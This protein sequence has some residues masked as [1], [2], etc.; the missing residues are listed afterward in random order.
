MKRIIWV[1]TRIEI[2]SWLQLVFDEVDR[3]EHFL[4]LRKISE[5]LKLWVNFY[6]EQLRVRVVDAGF[7][8]FYGCLVLLDMRQEDHF[9]GR[10]R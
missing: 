6:V 2:L 9:F 3:A 5:N 4:Q 10:I 8:F 7:L 1:I